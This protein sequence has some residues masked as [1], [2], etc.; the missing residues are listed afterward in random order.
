MPLAESNLEAEIEAGRAGDGEWIVPVF[1]ALLEGMAH[2]H[3]CESPV[4]HRDL[5]PLNILFV[6]GIPKV[7]DFGLGKRLD[8]EA[9]ALTRT[10]VGM[11]TE[12]YMAPE[13]FDNAKAVGPQADVYALGKILWQMLTGDVPEILHVDAQAV[14]ARYRYFIERCCRRDPAERYAN[15]AEALENFRRLAVNPQVVDPPIDTAEKLLAAW[16]GASQ[17]DR[18]RT[19]RDLDEHLQRSSSEYELYFKVVPRLPAGLI[20][21]YMDQIPAGF[22][23]MLRAY[24]RHISGSLP[25]AYCDRVADLYQRIFSRTADLELQR[26]TLARL[27]QMGSAHNRWYVGEVV[28]RLLGAIEDVSTAMIA[29]EVVHQHPDSAR[30]YWSPW[31]KDQAL[32]APIREAFEAVEG[33]DS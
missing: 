4:L 31:V 9:T 25:F 2:A 27:L 11:G 32:L 7:T 30:W 20:D 13:Q 33:K 15:A 29:A 10:D 23:S 21:L 19:A 3:K 8:P 1:S 18:L 16:D 17:D 14:P 6:N 22:A 5:K 28:G 26:L 12:P 24:D